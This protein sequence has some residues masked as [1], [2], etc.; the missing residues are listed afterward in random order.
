MQVPISMNDASN[1]ATEDFAYTRRTWNRPM[2][3]EF[4]LRYSMVSSENLVM[5]CSHASGVS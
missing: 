2:K 3:V 5:Y 1:A 4:K